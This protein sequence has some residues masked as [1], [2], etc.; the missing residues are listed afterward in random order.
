MDRPASDRE[1]TGELI[2]LIRKL[3][4]RE[5]DFTLV[6]GKK[7]RYYVDLKVTSLHPEGAHLIGVLAVEAVRREGLRVDGVGG[8]TLGADPLATSISLAARE[9]GIHWPALIVR[10]E[11]K[12]HGT[13]RYV[14]G[15]ENFEK[16]ARILVLEDSMT[17]GGSSI[18]AVERLREAGFE[19]VAVLTVVDREEGGEEAVRACGLPLL[20]L[21]TLTELREAG[22]P[23]QNS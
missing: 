23:D 1:R 20:R 9:E 17:T 22:E 21:V 2:R 19:P 7:S 3:S 13:G 15:G 16:G 14:E 18:K 10:K 6:S 5:G 8:L 12:G 11:A 4:Y